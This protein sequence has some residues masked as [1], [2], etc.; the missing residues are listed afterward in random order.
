MKKRILIIFS[1]CISLQINAQNENFLQGLVLLEQKKYEEAI[2]SFNAAL[3]DSP[4]NP[5]CW[6]RR[7][8]ALFCAKHPYE[9]INNYTMAIL[10]SPKNSP[11]YVQRALAYHE[12]GNFNA[13]VND[14]TTA[15]RIGDLSAQEFLERHS[16]SWKL[17]DN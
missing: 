3:K 4:S 10:L 6:E 12:T 15:A 7:G 8:Y 1:I 13:M 5:S 9:A 16:I 14:L 17:T 11:Y 2:T